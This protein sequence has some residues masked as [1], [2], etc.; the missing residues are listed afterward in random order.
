MLERGRD[1][2]HVEL[3]LGLV[4]GRVEVEVEPLEGLDLSLRDLQ[5]G[6]VRDAAVREEY[7][8]LCEKFNR[9]STSTIEYSRL[10]TLLC[11]CN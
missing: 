2:P 11:Y 8:R 9:P 7:A 5:R 4:L 3:D 1:V 10:S 6:Q